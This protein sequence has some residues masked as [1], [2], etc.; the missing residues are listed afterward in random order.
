MVGIV[1]GFRDDTQRR[2]ADRAIRE[3]E[4]RFRLVANTAPVM[5]WMAGVDKLC[6]YFNHPWLEFTG[7]SLEQELGNGWAEGVHPEDSER[8]LAIYVQAFDRRENFQ[9]EYRLR[10]HDGQYR[11]VFDQGVP[12]FDIDGSFAGYIGS[13]IDVTMHKLAEEALSSVSRRLIE[14]Q[15]EERGWLAR[16]LHDDINQRIAFLSVVLKRTVQELPDSAVVVKSQLE[17]S[18]ERAVALGS[19]VQALSHRLHSSKLDYLGLKTAAAGFCREFSDQQNVVIDFHSDELPRDLPKELSLSLFSV[20]QEAVQNAAKHSGT[21]RFRVTLEHDQNEIGLLV[22]DSG[23]GFDPGEAPR[24]RG[25]GLA[26]MTERLKLVNGQ[27]SIQSQPGNGTVICAKV[28]LRSNAQSA[29]AS[30]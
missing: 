10:R 25:V 15:E 14:A 9:M 11:W 12:R 1:V 28:S 4:E 24:G 17:S 22:A 6:T 20:L 26:N 8:C 29:S 23:K 2:Q 18:Y 30:G 16:E 3:N 27:L 21:N 13:A 19:D 5:I 7:R